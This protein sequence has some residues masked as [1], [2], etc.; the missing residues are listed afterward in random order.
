[1]FGGGFGA[2]A[3]GAPAGG[4]GTTT[5]TFGAPAQQ[6]TFGAPAAGTGTWRHAAAT[7]ARFDNAH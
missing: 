4:F 3:A 1:M 2:G 7:M 6:P 5:T